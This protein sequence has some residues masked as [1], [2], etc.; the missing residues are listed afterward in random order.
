VRLGIA[1]NVFIGSF[2]FICTKNSFFIFQVQNMSFYEAITK[3]HFDYLTKT[4][5]KIT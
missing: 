3:N 5:L 2:H 4:I 1:K